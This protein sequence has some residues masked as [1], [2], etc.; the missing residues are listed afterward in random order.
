MDIQEER[1]AILS[2]EGIYEVT[3]TGRIFTL[4]ENRALARCNDELSMVF[5]L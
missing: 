2:Y 1:R 5:I 3:S 4:R